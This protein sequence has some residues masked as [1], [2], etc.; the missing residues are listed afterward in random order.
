MKTTF[1]SLQ[2]TALR[3]VCGIVVAFS[4]AAGILVAQSLASQSLVAQ[5]PAP[6]IQAEVTSSAQSTLRGSLHPLA[7]AQND[8][9]R[10]PGGMRLNGVSLYFNRSAAQEADLQALLAA[11]QDRTS[12]L[13]HQWL[14]PEQYAARFG[15]AQA[16]LEK[17]QAWLQQQGFA[18]ESVARSHNMIRFSGS[19]SQVESAFGTQ[20]HYYNAGGAKHFAPSTALS[21]P[22]AIAP[23]V[24]GVRNLNDFRPRAQ[25]V[26]ARAAFTSSQSTSVF[27]SPGD[28]ST[29]YD[30]V[31]LTSA[32]VNG[33]GQTIVVAGQSWI[34]VG[35][36]E[37]FQ[38]AAGLAKKDPTMVLVPGT[39]SDGTPTTGDEG[40]SDLDVEWA[41][42][43]AP[44]ATIAFVYTGDDTNYGV[45]DSVAYAV[46]QKIGQ[47]ISLSYD[48]CELNL[49]ATDFTTLEA[50]FSQAA[51]QGQSVT[52]ASGDQGSTACFIENPPKSGDPTLATQEALAVNYPA[53]SAYVTGL[54]GARIDQTNSAYETQGQG[55]WA[56]QGS[57]DIISSALKYI[58]EEAW[59]D[60]NA[61]NGL[62]ASGGGTSTTI[63][64]P[65]WQA[66][67]P[68][69]PSGSKRLVPDVSLFSSPNFPGYLFCT[70]DQGDW[71][72]GQTGSCGNG[73]RASSSDVS[74]TAAGGTSFAAPVFAGMLALINQK[75]GYTTG[76]GLINPTLY[77]LAAN[78]ATYAAAF[79]DITSGNNYCTAGSSFCASN[80][81]TLGYKAGTGYDQVTGLGSVDLTVLAN[82]WPVNSGS[83]ASLIGST[84]TVSVSNPTPNIGD[85]VTFT[86]T[87]APIA[88]GGTPS[89]TVNLSVDGGGTEYSDGGT[90]SSVTLSANGTAT[91]TASFTSAGTHSVVAKYAGDATYAA[92]T[93]SGS[94]TI[95]IV[96]SGKG[97]IA[98]SPSPSTLTVAQGASGNET[99]TITPSS[100]YTGYVQL[101]YTTPTQLNNLCV[102]AGSGIDSSGSV[103]VGSA[104]PVTAVLEIDTTAADCSAAGASQSGTHPLRL[105]RT[106]AAN[107][108]APRPSPNRIPAGAAL[109]SLV[110][111]GFLGRYA[112]K[113]R[114]AA[115]ILVL[116][117]AG[118]A[119]SACGGGGGSSSGGGTSNPPKGSYTITLTG[120]DS[121]T[122]TI[123]TTATFKLTIN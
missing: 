11:Q 56:A 72:S 26:R 65:T 87:V 105:R 88:V 60:D 23:V 91:F 29:V 108:P 62:S 41:G 81:A 43:L 94:V 73:F 8:A 55:Y 93:G 5:S 78:S 31:P 12:P 35:D 42:A 46:D 53:S 38:T 4:M 36:V 58:P 67:V 74:L 2:Q 75:A 97:T 110:L 15:A 45:F 22:S 80:G 92:S 32:G 3:R 117:A 106:A 50:I 49:Q 59:N 61:T 57:S 79:H 70:S 107:H 85:T 109:A 82:A 14:T 111:A 104:N 9:G 101:S 86:I 114:S 54:G 20:M 33:L 98:I 63:V 100:G 24:A 84:T 76:Q 89:G 102:F 16:D 123:T 122:S 7:Q 120:T 28:I 40:E 44:G 119:T 66:G 99:L 27:F 95:T 112:R 90:A 103:A 116:A 21:L 39:G 1:A 48:T 64:R 68:G 19:V 69:I 6:R 25:H 118:L 30:V 13:Y 34:D 96:S 37:H 10:M 52:V 17:V 51:T 121:V 83:S 71:S 47:I 113:F 18:I 115:W 77:T